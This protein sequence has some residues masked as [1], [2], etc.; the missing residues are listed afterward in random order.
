MIIGIIA[1]SRNYAIGKDG[2]LPW[3]YPAD[4]KFFKETTTGN[5]VVMGRT[6]WVS[7]GRP[8]PNRLNI[9]LSRGGSIEPK[10]G[11]IL[12]R[13]KQEVLS[14]AD[15]LKCDVFIIGGSKTYQNFADVI[16]KWIVTEI[17]ETVENA[18][19][20]MPTDFLENFGHQ[21]ELVLDGG[22]KVNSYG[23]I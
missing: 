3:H 10:A 11:I 21:N 6:T 14:V 2:K 8:L 7:I 4:L 13:S 1:I 19:V 20:F 15:Y 9:V 5:A 18:D 17:P 16:D 22:L 23:R 12:L